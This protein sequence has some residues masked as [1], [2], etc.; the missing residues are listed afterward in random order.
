LELGLQKVHR[1]VRAREELARDL[2]AL[3]QE[4]EQD[5]LGA[6]DL[7]AR[8]TRFVA[9]KEQDSLRLFGELLEHSRQAPKVAAL[10]LDG[11][12]L[13]A[14]ISGLPETP[15]GQ[16]RTL[17]RE[18][19]LRKGARFYHTCP[20]ALRC[21]SRRRWPCRDASTASARVRKPPRPYGGRD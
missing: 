4:P 3:F 2:L 12:R 9:G 13:P 8:L 17:L 10:I 15:G 1:H 18:A 5:V 11:P 6:D 21:A 7:G 14:E 16:N 19:H 20:R